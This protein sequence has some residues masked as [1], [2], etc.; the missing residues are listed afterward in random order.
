[1]RSAVIFFLFLLSNALGIGNFA[2]AGNHLPEIAHSP[3]TRIE[4]TA[5]APT[6]IANN[7]LLQIKDASGAE[8][9]TD[10]IYVEDDDEEENSLRKQILT[11]KGFATFCYSFFLSHCCSDPADPL[12]FYKDPFYTGS[13]KYIVQR[14]LRI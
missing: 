7:P 11:A 12:S 1:M 14:V 13:C 8:E 2:Y 6:E 5:H 4:K 3:S 9:N 10:L